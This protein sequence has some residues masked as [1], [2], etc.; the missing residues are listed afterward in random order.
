MLHT[1]VLKEKYEHLRPGAQVTDTVHICPSSAGAV[2]AL[3]G[4]EVGERVGCRLGCLDGWF[5]GFAVVGWE[6]GLGVG[7]GDGFFVGFGVGW[8]AGTNVGQVYAIEGGQVG[9][10]VRTALTVGAAAATSLSP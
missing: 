10:H 9:G 4:S 1:P 7:L 3:V 2:G 5:V 6:V 8:L